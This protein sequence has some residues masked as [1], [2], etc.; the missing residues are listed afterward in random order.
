M[1]E[2]TLALDTSGK[3]VGREKVVE[4]EGGDGGVGKNL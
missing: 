4:G 3:E 1:G 2:H